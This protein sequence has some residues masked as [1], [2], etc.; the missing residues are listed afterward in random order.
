MRVASSSSAATASSSHSL[1]LP[2]AEEDSSADSP[3]DSKPNGN[4]YGLVAASGD[5]NNVELSMTTDSL[6]NSAAN[7]GTKNGNA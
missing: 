2:V 3:I 1:L 6:A 4:G 5:D 7:S